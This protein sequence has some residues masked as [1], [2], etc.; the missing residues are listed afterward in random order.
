MIHKYIHS[1]STSAHINMLNVCLS[2][3]PMSALKVAQVST[4]IVHVS[5]KY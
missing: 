4:C 3:L 2:S 1:T 5:L